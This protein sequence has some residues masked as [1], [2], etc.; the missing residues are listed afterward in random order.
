M[1]NRT[2]RRSVEQKRNIKNTDWSSEEN[3]KPNAKRATS[4]LAKVNENS[5]LLAR[6]CQKESRNKKTKQTMDWNNM[7]QR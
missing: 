7:E 4:D 6:K 5:K 3:E 1:D 2:T